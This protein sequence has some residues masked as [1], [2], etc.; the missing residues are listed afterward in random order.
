MATKGDSGMRNETS[1][2]PMER[3]GVGLNIMEWMLKSYCAML[4]LFLR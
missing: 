2:S 1:S 4:Q 3:I